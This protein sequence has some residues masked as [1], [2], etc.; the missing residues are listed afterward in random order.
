LK[1][2]TIGL[3]GFLD[4]IDINSYQSTSDTKV[5]QFCQLYKSKI[6]QFSAYSKYRTNRKILFWQRDWYEVN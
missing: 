2:L 4:M 6:A 1:L 3:S 5:H